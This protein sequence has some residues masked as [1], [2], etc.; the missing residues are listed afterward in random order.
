MAIATRVFPS[1]RRPES[2]RSVLARLFATCA[3]ALTLSGCVYYDITL[4]NGDVVRAK[5]KPKKDEQG[6]YR[7][8]DLAGRETTINPMRVRQIEPVRR[9]SP[10]SRPF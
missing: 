8:K 3:L 2:I 1:R 6:Y 9:S 10:P 4:T 5:G 7:F